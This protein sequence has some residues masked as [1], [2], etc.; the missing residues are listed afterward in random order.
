MSNYWLDLDKLK[1]QEQ[2]NWDF[3]TALGDTIREKYE[4]KYV[5]IVEVSNVINRRIAR[6][7]IKW[8]TK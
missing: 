3:Q 8:D 4:S 1:T 2:S 5:R 6:S 7:A